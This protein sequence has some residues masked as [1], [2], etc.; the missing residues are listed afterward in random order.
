LCGMLTLGVHTQSVTI[1]TSS[2]KKRPPSA[3]SPFSTT[4][5][6]E[7]LEKLAGCRDIPYVEEAYAVVT[8]S[9][10]EI[11]LRSSMSPPRRAVRHDVDNV[12]SMEAGDD[13]LAMTFRR[14]LSC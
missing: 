1:G 8:T 6:N 12:C 2:G 11:D 3:A 7:S 5:S 9:G 13:V 14:R 4:V 10:R